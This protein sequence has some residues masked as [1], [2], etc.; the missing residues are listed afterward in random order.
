MGVRDVYIIM[1]SFAEI[2]VSPGE[3][4]VKYTRCRGG[5][6]VV[7]W[8]GGGVGVRLRDTDAAAQVDVLLF[9]NRGRVKRTRDF[10]IVRCEMLARSFL[11]GCCLPVPVPVPTPQ[12]SKTI[13]FREK[14]HGEMSAGRIRTDFA[15]SFP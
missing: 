1:Y 14:L 3:H 5:G 7:G 8:E 9:R 13:G 2:R 11:H 4:C 12:W 6:E 10:T 15:I